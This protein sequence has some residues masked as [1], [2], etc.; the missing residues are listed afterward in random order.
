M[1]DDASPPSAFKGRDASSYDAVT[2]SFDRFTRRF[3][4]PLARRLVDLAEPEPGQEVLD[5]GTGT[6]VVALEAARRVGPEGRVLGVD[7]SDGMLRA[8]RDRAVEAGLDRVV[9]FR[10]EDAESL[11]LADGSFDAVVSLYALL[12]FPNPDVALREMCRVTRPGGRAVVAIGTGP[13]R[14][15]LAWLSYALRRAPARLQ[16]RRGRWMAAPDAMLR[17]LESELPPSAGEEE[18]R[19]AAHRGHSAGTLASMLR[20]AGFSDVRT[21]WRA[22]V[23]ALDTADD[24]WDLQATFSSVARKRLAEADPAVV[25]WLRDLLRQRAGVVLAAGGRLVYPY[26]AYY[27]VGRRR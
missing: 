13:P 3:T 15:S 17:L 1:T 10:R 20:R 23:G 18:T 22:G 21:D 12:H 5:V 27:A 16:I 14:G 24:F 7:L 2:S 9:A 19:L 25:A 6:G 11:T 8:A 26:A 4:E